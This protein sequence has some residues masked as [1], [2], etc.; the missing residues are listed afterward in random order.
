L[1]GDDEDYQGEEGGGGG[2]QSDGQGSPSTE[3]GQSTSPRSHSESPQSPRSPSCS[4]PAP[5]PQEILTEAAPDRPSPPDSVIEMNCGRD[6]PLP[7][8]TLRL[9]T[10][11]ASDPALQP[12]AKD[13][14]DTIRLSSEDEKTVDRVEQEE[15]EKKLTKSL[16]DIRMEKVIHPT[17]TSPV[18]ALPAAVPRMQVFTCGPCGIRFSSLSTLEAHQTYYCSH[19]KEPDDAAGAKGTTA[20][21]SPG[22]QEPPVK[23]QR[24][25]KQY[26]CSQCSYSADKKVSLNRHMRM[27]QTSPAPSSTT[28]NGDEP[29]S[30]TAQVDRYCSDCDIRFSSTKTYRA[31]KQ[32]YCSSRHRDGQI[33]NH[34]SSK[35]PSIVKGGSQSPPEIAKSPPTAQPQAYLAL[36]TN[37]IVIVP[38]S[39]IRGA[40]LLPGPLTSLAQNVTNPEATCFLLQ[41]G[42]LTPIAQALSVQAPIVNQPPSRG[43]TPASEKDNGVTVP[44][45]L[46]VVNKKDHQQLRDPTIPLDLSV[47][48]LP[49]SRERSQSFSSVASADAISRP[50]VDANAEGKENVSVGSDSLTP[51]QIVCAPSLPGSPPLTPS[52]KRRSNSPRGGSISVSP[53]SI[54]MRP[55]LPADLTPQ[56][57][58]RLNNEAVLPPLVPGPSP[59]APPANAAPLPPQIFVKQGVSKCKECN[60]VFCKYENYLAHKKH[61]CSARNLDDPEGAKVSPPVSP[62]ATSPLAQT[63]PQA[64]TVA[65]GGLA[66]QQLICAACGIKFTS[67]DNLSA[68][69]MYYC[70]KRVEL[71]VQQ[72]LIQKD[73]CTKCK[74]VHDPNIPC[75]SSHVGSS[76]SAGGYKCPICDVVSTNAA[77]SRRHMETH[78]GVKAFRCS[79]CRYKGNTLRGMRTH[80]RMHFEKKTTDFNEENY[81]TCILEEDGVEIPP[82]AQINPETLQPQMH[83]CDLCN[84]S[85]SYKGNVVRHIKLVHSQTNHQSNSPSIGEGGESLI[86]N[87]NSSDL[88]GSGTSIKISLPPRNTS[89][90]SSQVSVSVKIEPEQDFAKTEDEP[91]LVIDDSDV[92]VKVEASDRSETPLGPPPPRK[93]PSPDDSMVTGGPKYCKT[94][95]IRFNYLNTFI[96]HKKF[97]CKGT[98]V[99]ALLPERIVDVTTNNTSPKRS[100]TSPAPAVVTTSV[101]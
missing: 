84:Y 7:K 19:R 83:S 82:A 85:S 88:S 26:A 37:P 64:V 80:I 52:P 78:G 1:T 36:P 47:R 22:S 14:K 4:T 71:A 45:V 28:S 56:V 94:C 51:E 18:D 96:A 57:L 91:E 2:L 34:V 3:V 87:G 50:D 69:Q 21:D 95:D 54:L 67:L 81:I 66:Y 32:H 60:I 15:A 73:R 16:K 62:T 49:T 30:Q 70:P 39:V 76:G 41:N 46:R 40:S 72:S 99:D 12:E 6:T 27:H 65:G 61:Y 17:R 101:L 79:I 29:P 25:G 24:T 93:T 42:A 9:N 59:G 5:S 89:R 75:P 48:R 74:I 23:A 58:V 13:L 35:P 10:K 8:P 97:Y 44:D 63:G 33:V 98:N 11:L 31:H 43:P 77:E 53:N 38:C 86:H 90:P 20:A 55:L 68:H 100:P 92:V